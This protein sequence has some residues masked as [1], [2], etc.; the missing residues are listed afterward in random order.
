[1]N[2]ATGKMGKR[3]NLSPTT[4]TIPN[5]VPAS[6]IATTDS[7]KAEAL[8][9]WF[10]PPMPYADLTDILSAS[11]QIEM[12]FPMFVSEEMIS[13]VIKKLH[14]FKAA[15]S[16][17]ILFFVFECLGSPLFSFFQRLFHAC[18]NLSDHHTAFCHCITVPLKKPGKGDY[19]VPGAWQSIALHNTLGKVLES[20]IIWQTSSLSE[21]DFLLP[22]KHMGAYHCR[23][24]DTALDFLVKQ[25][26]ETVQNKDGVA[27]LL[28]LIMTGDFDRIVPAWL[29]HSVRERKLC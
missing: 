25:I 10:F 20:V 28:S 14:P 8:K 4:P 24:L 26:N 12:F 2:I 29:L 15:G 6:K 21:V 17:G 7:K 11:Y 9:S 27:T 16:D 1:M 13:S 5:L 19:T 22:G 23:S 3:K 18:I